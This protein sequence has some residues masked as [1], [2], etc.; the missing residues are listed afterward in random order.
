MSHFTTLGIKIV[1]CKLLN[2]N[3]E[4]HLKALIEIR[5]YTLVF[6]ICLEFYGT[7]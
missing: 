3:Q 2:L 7:I 6:K 4:G 1:S 5:F